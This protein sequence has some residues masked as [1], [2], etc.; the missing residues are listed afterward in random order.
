MAEF[1]EWRVI[2]LKKISKIIVALIVVALLVA[3]VPY[4]I[5][6]CADCEKFFVGPGYD[7]NI[8]VDAL[9]ESENV[10]CR[11]CA[12]LHHAISSAL[13]KGV[14]EYR[15]PLIENPVKLITELFS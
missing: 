7:A 4:Y 12:E 15:R 14:D 6:T 1:I 5:H 11:E 3:Y 8:L 9:S 10:I 13:G 2:M